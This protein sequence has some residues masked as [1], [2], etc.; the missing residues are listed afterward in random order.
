LRGESKPILK[1][2]SGGLTRFFPPPYVTFEN[3]L[4]TYPEVTKVSV[5][6]IVPSTGQL[7]LNSLSPSNVR[8]VVEH[9]DS[10]GVVIL[11]PEAEKI[12][13]VEVEVEFVFVRH[14]VAN[15]VNKPLLAPQCWPEF[16]C[17]IEGTLV[18]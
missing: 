14:D 11:E 18:V 15:D 4:S 16:D 6:I 8:L 3:E 9:V 17:G 2:N 13:C 5:A 7:V 12:S 1:S 10:V